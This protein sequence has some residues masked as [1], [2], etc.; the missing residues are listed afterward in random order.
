MTARVLT[1]FEAPPDARRC[2]DCARPVKRPRD[3]CR[4]CGAPLSFKA[5]KA[6][7][8]AAVKRGLGLR[9]PWESR[10]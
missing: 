7:A 1:R 3:T 4:A 6:R 2:P 8:E 10:P 9:G 5:F